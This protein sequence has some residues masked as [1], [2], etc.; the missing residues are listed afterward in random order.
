MIEAKRKGFTLIE[1]IVAMAIFSIFALALVFVFTGQIQQ[2]A[3]QRSIS[4]AQMDF[5]SAVS[6]MKWDVLMAGYGLSNAQDPLT[7]TDGNP[8]NLTIRTVDPPV[9]GSG[10]WTFILTANTGGGGNNTLL[11]KR[12]N[13]P[14][15][16]IA[17]GD[18]ITAISDTK[19]PLS[20][21][22]VTVTAVQNA[23]FQAPDTTVSALLLTL[24][25]NVSVGMGNFVFVLPSNPADMNVQYTLSGNQLL[26][27]NVPVIDNVE[28]F[29][30]AY[31]YDQNS[32]YQVDAG[33]L[34]NDISGLSSAAKENVRLVR[35][36]LVVMGA[37]DLKYRYPDNQ[38]TL[39]NHTYAVTDSMRRR[40]IYTFLVKTRNLK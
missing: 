1:L 18:R 35:L 17:V 28:D 22:P 5:Q 37:R 40:R 23:S 10:K 6:L 14:R 30:I 33:E 39:E 36:N 31:W 15:K 2:A 7:G 12:W 20:G 8:D 4:K 11:V 34:V 24:S 38:I 25:S 9:G 16:D 26:R 27:N 19:E 3:R 13:D 29:E 21:F 32:N